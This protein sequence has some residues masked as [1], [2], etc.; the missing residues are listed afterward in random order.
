MKPYLEITEANFAAMEA[1]AG[2]SEEPI[3]MVNLIQVKS[4]AE[5]DDPALN[6]C[7]GPEGFAR[8]LSVGD[9]VRE[10]VG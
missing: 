7:T 1:F 3:V 9:A 6:G 10:E 2:S 8:Y 5:C 4:H